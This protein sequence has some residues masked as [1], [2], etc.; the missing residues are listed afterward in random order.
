MLGRSRCAGLIIIIRFKLNFTTKQILHKTSK[1]LNIKLLVYNLTQIF[2]LGCRQTTP[3]K[4]LRTKLTWACPGVEPG[5][6]RTRSENHTTR[7]TGPDMDIN[8]IMAAPFFVWKDRLLWSIN[9][10]KITCGKANEELS[11]SLFSRHG[12]LGSA[13]A[14][15]VHLR[16]S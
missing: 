14:N 13:E 11:R 9:K 12:M 16:M 8:G 7:S 10:C 5:T 2:L 4:C 3:G 6:S 15:R 1:T